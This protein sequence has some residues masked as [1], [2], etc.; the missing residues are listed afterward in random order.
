MKEPMRCSDTGSGLTTRQIGK[1]YFMRTHNAHA[2][3]GDNIIS[4]I[5]HAGTAQFDLGTGR[6]VTNMRPKWTITSGLS[7]NSHWLARAVT[8]SC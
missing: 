3:V 5:S 2:D 7:N 4:G 6:R 8:S 1:Q